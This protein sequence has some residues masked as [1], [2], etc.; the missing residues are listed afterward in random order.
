MKQIIKK[1]LHIS[2]E[3]THNQ[4]QL[5]FSHQ[6]YKSSK[7]IQNKLKVNLPPRIPLINLNLPFIKIN[8]QKHS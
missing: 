3:I 6:W 2:K 4:A 5:T 7:E 1:K 8:I